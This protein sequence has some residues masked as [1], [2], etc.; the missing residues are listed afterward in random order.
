MSA[1]LLILLA[2]VATVL[3]LCTWL[4]SRSGKSIRKAELAIKLRVRIVE[5][6]DEAEGIKSFRLKHEAGLRLPQP[7]AGSHISIWLSHGLVRHYSI[8]NVGDNPDHYQIAMKL[9]E[10]SRGGSQ[11]MYSLQ[12]GEIL[13]ISTPRNNFKLVEEA[14]EYL[15]FAGGIGITPLFAMVRALEKRRAKYH[16]HYFTRS[17]GHTA[18]RDELS[19]QELATKVTFHHGVNPEDLA[20]LLAQLMKAPDGA[21]LYMCGP[22]SFMDA[23]EEAAAPFFSRD[24]IHREYFSADPTALAAPREEFEVELAKSGKTLV[25]PAEASILK[26]LKDSGIHVEHSC[27][28]GICGTCLTHV[29]DGEPDH[30]DSFL[31]D[32]EQ[33][34]GDRMLVCV[35]RAKSAKLVLEL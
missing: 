13:E 8:C 12:E 22:H 2:F 24:C 11:S 15:L 14:C 9:E 10:E 35:S 17:R 34:A 7:T 23:V 32:S 27:E 26:V 5:I 19:V 30:R 29:L 16:L 31:T 33:K 4:I 3:I 1:W 28:E 6:R 20:G 25:V 21:H 18:F